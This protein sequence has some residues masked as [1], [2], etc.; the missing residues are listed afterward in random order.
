MKPRSKKWRSTTVCQKPYWTRVWIV[1]E[2]GAAVDLEIHWDVRP[3]HTKKLILKFASWNDFF[4]TV[5]RLKADG[6]SNRANELA[7]QRKNRH[8]DAFLLSNLIEASADAMCE[9]PQDKIYGFVGI[10]ARL[11]RWQFSCRLCEISL[12]GI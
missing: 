10:C 1:Q 3:K 9:L 4:D 12:E 2:V 6:A 7:Q 11:R 8:G 5:Q